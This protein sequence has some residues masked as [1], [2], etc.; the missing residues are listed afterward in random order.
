VFCFVVKNKK[1]K[2]KKQ[3]TK[4]KKQK[5]IPAGFDA[6]APHCGIADA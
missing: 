4:N 3:K 1:Q 5:V 2:T 6:D